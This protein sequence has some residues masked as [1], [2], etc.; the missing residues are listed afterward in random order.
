MHDHMPHVTTTTSCAACGTTDQ[1]RGIS[2][3]ART[4]RWLCTTCDVPRT[5]KCGCT[6]ADAYRHT[7]SEGF[8]CRHR[9]A[10]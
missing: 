2:Y 7:P 5:A 8:T 10:V 9:N 3:D 6:R 1:L 4:S